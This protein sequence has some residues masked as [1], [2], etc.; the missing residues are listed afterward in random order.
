MANTKINV[1]INGA[2]GKMG[3]E[4]TKAITSD[5]ELNLVA[6]LNRKDDLAAAIKE[7]NSKDN[8]VVVVDLTSSQC[9]L[10]NAKIIITHNACPVI[11]SS[12]LLESDTKQLQALAT[13]HK[14]NGIIVP[15]FSLGAVLMMHF[16]TLAAKF[17]NE[18]EIIERHHRD[19]L[20]SPSGTAIRTADLIA[21]NLLSP[22]NAKQY[23][24]TI[25]AARGASYKNIAIHSVRLNGSCG[26]QS[27]I[28]GGTDETLTITHDS[29]HRSS[30]MP[31]IILAC[32]KAS[33]QNGLVIGLEH[34]LN[35]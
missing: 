9:V 13:Q 7:Y 33:T 31:G 11:G 21:K 30:F 10:E 14:V 5:T 20:D 34:L 4:A 19:K 15:N 6:G 27:V 22:T 16:S 29:L 28:F 25:P 17:F 32:K 3:V 8:P 2:S 23:H 18:V 1:I 26:H 24:E 35:L 12:G